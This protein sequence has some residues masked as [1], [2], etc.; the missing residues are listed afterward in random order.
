[1][2]S[3]HKFLPI[4]L[5]SWNKENIPVNIF[6]RQI[7]PHPQSSDE[8]SFVKLMAVNWRQFWLCGNW[9]PDWQIWQS[10]QILANVRHWNGQKKRLFGY[11]S[12]FWS[13]TADCIERNKIAQFIVKYH[14]REWLSSHEINDII[15]SIMIM[16][17]SIHLYLHLMV[18][19][20]H[21]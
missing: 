4:K 19:M 3:P 2:C 20:L 17:E 9:F 8:S 18:M 12:M 6:L 14:E 16:F 13:R 10:G 21:G 7:L 1:M 5:K 15:L 11:R